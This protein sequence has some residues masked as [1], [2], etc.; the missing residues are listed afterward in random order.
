[1]MLATVFIEAQ[2]VHALCHLGLRR[3]VGREQR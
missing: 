1:M 3:A 2:K